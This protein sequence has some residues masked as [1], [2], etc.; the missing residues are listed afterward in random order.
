MGGNE[1]DPNVVSHVYGLDHRLSSN[2]KIFMKTES[3]IVA[4][5]PPQQY[6]HSLHV[7]GGEANVWSSA[8]FTRLSS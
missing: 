6:T 1:C 2:S 7:A 4:H 3:N 5:I 8:S